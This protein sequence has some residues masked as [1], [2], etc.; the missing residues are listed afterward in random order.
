MLSW[1]F[2]F[3]FMGGSFSGRV[4]SWKCPGGGGGGVPEVKP[5]PIDECE[6][7]HLANIEPQSS[8]ERQA[9]FLKKDKTQSLVT[10]SH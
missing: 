8:F 6:R 10:P 9:S 5:G 2:L 1:S 4:I 7:V 3:V